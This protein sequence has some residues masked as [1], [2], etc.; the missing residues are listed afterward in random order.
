MRQY[1]ARIHSAPIAK[2][3]I[4]PKSA[5]QK[6]LHRKR[7][8]DTGATICRMQAGKLAT[9]PASTLE[10]RQHTRQLTRCPT[11]YT[12]SVLLGE[13]V[14][15]FPPPPRP[16]RRLVSRPETARV[17]EAVCPFC[18][19]FCLE[20]ISNLNTATADRQGSGLGWVTFQSGSLVDWKR[21]R[22]GSGV[23]ILC[24]LLFEVNAEHFITFCNYTTYVPKEPNQST[25]N[26]HGGGSGVPI[27][28]TSY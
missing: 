13:V 16:D 22:W 9:P 3:Q 14:S 10:R 11:V 18:V 2:S 21:P 15:L 5:R 19:A 1:H 8:R 7:N 25:G 26:G 27:C 23:P 20:W 4:A 28:V 6:T 24:H 17:G 12:S